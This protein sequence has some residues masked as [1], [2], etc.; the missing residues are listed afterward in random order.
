MRE[1]AKFFASRVCISLPRI[2]K[3]A[4]GYLDIGHTRLTH[5]FL[6]CGEVQYVCGNCVVPLTVRN[7]RD[8]GAIESKVAVV[9][10]L[11]LKE[12]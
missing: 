9:S 7:L 12:S 6:V 8:C 3:T 2:P 1:V 10:P 11:F 5:D 4:L